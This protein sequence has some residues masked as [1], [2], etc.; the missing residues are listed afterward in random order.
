M[1]KG[2]VI[3]VL[4]AEAIGEGDEGLAAVAW[5]IMNRAAETGRTPAQVVSDP[6]DYTGAS[7]PGS[8]TKKAMKDPAIRA[9]VE[10]VWSQ[11]QSGS[12][13][14]PTGGATHYWAPNGMKGGKAPYWAKSE[15]SDA[16]RLKIGNHVFLPKQ[17][18]NSALSAINAAAPQPMPARPP[19]L[20]AFASTPALDP[21]RSLQDALNAKAE[22]VR[23]GT[24]TPVSQKAIV[25]PPKP[26]PAPPPSRG[27]GT[28]YLA[29]ATKVQTVRIDPM[30]NKVIAPNAPLTRS[31]VTAQ[32]PAPRPVSKP[33]NV[34]FVPSTPAPTPFQTANRNLVQ[35]LPIV[36]PIVTGL[37][38]AADIVQRVA[39]ATAQAKPAPQPT[40]LPSVIPPTPKGY[41]T[42]TGKYEAMQP[43]TPYAAG[44]APV[45]VADNKSPAR[46]YPTVTPPTMRE[47]LDEQALMRRPRVPQLTPATLPRL[48][49]PKPAALSRPIVP[50][51]TAP[52]PAAR[53]PL[54]Q[55]RTVNPVSQIIPAVQAR[56]GQ[57]IFGQLFNM[58]TAGNVPQ[59]NTGAPAAPG[60]NGSTTVT[61]NDLRPTHSSIFSDNAL[62]PSGMNNRRWA[63]DGY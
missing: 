58:L 57:G 37:G 22:R 25:T 43:S 26:M 59:A 21:M 16:G 49:I 40:R 61:S 47:T 42:L 6:G 62:L 32:A 44:P 46:L 1:A 12:I 54:P 36:G 17:S 8:A 29:P 7:N 48:P 50:V 35:G 10:K 31:P 60:Y 28:G 4:I 52:I 45:R 24:D 18:P 19:T 15:T 39:P 63:G 9:K 11:V 23:A 3:D 56:A 51:R 27:V 41:N 14:D 5:T 53:I 2:D 34:T 33:P 38:A 20:S 13:P 55:A 30:T